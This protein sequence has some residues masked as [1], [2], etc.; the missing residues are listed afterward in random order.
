MSQTLTQVRAS[1][2]AQH[3]SGI[4]LVLLCTAL[5]AA[6]QIL[7]KMGGNGLAGHTAGEI[8]A[9]PALILK[10]MPLIIG[11]SLYGLSTVF[12]V[13]ALRR[14]ELSILYPIISLTYVWVLVL[15]VMIFQEHLNSWKL[16]GIAAIVF[17]V[18]VLGRDSRS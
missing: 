6:A 12:M 3:R 15:S 4:F 5:G 11:Y 17:G 2:A 16:L 13:L 18:S 14:G 8:L 7:L 10:N 9:Q 1:P